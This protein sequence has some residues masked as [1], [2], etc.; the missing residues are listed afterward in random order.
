MNVGYGRKELAEAAYEQMLEL[1]FYNTF[2]KT[3]TVPAIN[4]ATKVAEKLGGNLQHVFFN[5]S[6]SEANDTVMRMVRHYWNVKGE[7]KRTIFVSRCRSSSLLTSAWT[8]LALPPAALI[9]ATTAWAWSG[10]D[11]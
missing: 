1:P 10:L 8:A 4:L 7:P 11:E 9:L 6:G 2:F 5:S 3:A